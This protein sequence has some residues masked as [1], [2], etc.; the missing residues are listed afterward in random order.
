MCARRRHVPE[1][2]F[3]I[4]EYS[5]VVYTKEIVELGVG[6]TPTPAVVLPDRHNLAGCPI[7]ERKD[8]GIQ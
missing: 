3:S 7:S 2:Y 8:Y 6:M 5:L 1:F 4:S